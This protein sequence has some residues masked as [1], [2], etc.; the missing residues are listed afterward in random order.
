M[1]KTAKRALS[2]V[3]AGLLFLGLFAIAAAA[4]ET[5]PLV[6]DIAEQ[7]I[8]EPEA[9]IAEDLDAQALDP[10]LEVNFETAV[11][12][13]AFLPAIVSPSG[14]DGLLVSG[15][16]VYT[17]E[18]AR[19]TRY[20]IRTTSIGI[21]PRAAKVADLFGN[22]PLSGAI[23][24]VLS[25]ILS[26][27]DFIFPNTKPYVQVFVDDDGLA[28][29]L[30]EAGKSGFPWWKFNQYDVRLTFDCEA[31]KTYYVVVS[32]EETTFNLPFLLYVWPWI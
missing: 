32:A 2:V 23:F 7:E 22:F 26:V 19:T 18:A 9:A 28:V 29:P 27:L 1:A 6:F 3:L 5:E 30:T 16:N 24:F 11:K 14:Y 17:F 21:Y 25:P 8:A 20:R 10:D 31:G 13:N 4:D 12:L 15:S